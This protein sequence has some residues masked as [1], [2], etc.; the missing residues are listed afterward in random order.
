MDRFLTNDRN[1]R[2]HPPILDRSKLSEVPLIWTRADIQ[3][4]LV[5]SVVFSLV[6][7]VQ[8]STQTRIKIIGRLPGTDEWVPIDEDEAAQEEIPGVVSRIRSFALGQADYIACRANQRE[9]KLCQ[10]WST[11]RTTTPSK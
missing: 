5:A 6:L 7:V 8:K 1:F 2:S 11:Q 9:S 10:Y 4:G 3:T